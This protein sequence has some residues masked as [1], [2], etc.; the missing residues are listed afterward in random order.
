M[1]MIRYG[2]AAWS[3]TVTVLLKKKTKCLIKSAVKVFGNKEPLSFQTI[4]DKA[5]RVIYRTFRAEQ[6]I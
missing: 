1:H 6:V 5:I 2:I 4:N 3:S